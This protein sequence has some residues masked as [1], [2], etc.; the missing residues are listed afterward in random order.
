MFTG[1][2]SFKSRHETSRH[3]PKTKGSSA[4]IQRIH[5]IISSSHKQEHSIMAA[6]EYPNVWS[7]MPQT[8][9]RIFAPSVRETSYAPNSLFDCR[10]QLLH[11]W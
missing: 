2:E 10:V 9:I 7:F 4:L 8:T 5:L 6:R 3:L 11:S 1:R